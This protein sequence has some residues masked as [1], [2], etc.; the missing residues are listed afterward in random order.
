MNDET[1][2]HRIIKPHW[3]LQGQEVSS[4]AFRPSP[5]DEGQLSVYDGDQITAEASWRHYTGDPSQPLPS[6]VMS[7]T[8]ADCSRQALPVRPDPETFPEHVL[9]DFRQFGT[10]QIRRK[11]ERLRDAATARGWQFQP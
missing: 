7:V 2:L 6:G 4:Q 9:I 8:V 10:N 1:L 3:W 5:R 11:S